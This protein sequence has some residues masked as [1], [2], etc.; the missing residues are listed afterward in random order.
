MKLYYQ[1][2]RNLGCEELQ[3]YKLIIFGP[4]GVGKSSLFKVLLGKNPDTVRNSTGAFNRK[5]VQAKVAITTPTSESKSSWHLVNIKDEISR[6]RSII[7]R[8]I[9]KRKSAEVG[10]PADFIS[11]NE[12]QMKIEEEL[13]KPSVAESA[14]IKYASILMVCYDSGGQPEFFDIMPALTTIPTG[15]IMV[16]NLTKDLY[17]KIDSE[18]YEEGESSQSQYQAHYTTAELM[19]TAIANIQSYSAEKISSVTSSSSSSGSNAGRLL[20]V[21]THL[22]LCGK[23]SREKQRIIDKMETVM[24]ND[25]LAGKLMQM[26]HCDF[27]GRIIHCISNKD[28]VG[29]DKAAQKIRTAIEDMSKQHEKS[30]SEV[31]INWLL[32][33]LEIQLEMQLTGKEYIGWNKC[34]EIAKDCYIKENEVGSV[35]MYFHELGVLLHYKEVD[36]LKDIIFCN[37]QWLFDQLT[38]L[39]KIKYKATPMIQKNINK[40]TLDKQQLCKLYSKKLDLKGELK[41][42]N[43][44][45]LFVHLKIMSKLPNKPDQYFM[46]ALLNPAPTNISLQEQIGKKVH[47]TMLV[48]FKDRYFPR[49]MFCCLVTQLSQNGWEI[50]CM[51]AYKN[52]IVFQNLPNQYIVLYDEINYMEVEIHCNEETNFQTNHYEVCIT[53]NDCL[54][55]VCEM[56]QMNCNFELGFVCKNCKIFAGVESLN[57]YSLSTKYCCRECGS[58]FDLNHGQLVWFLPPNIF[59]LQV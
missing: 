23:T 3:L 9:K 54:T 7:E 8:V 38:E 44:L 33:Q 45:E 30:Y 28:S 48:K 59:K 51:H 50:Q 58:S 46:P 31:P 11:H 2:K 13:F 40:G 19:K 21:G 37:P 20:V 43:L 17:S 27:D 39:I 12:S 15:N 41:F 4:P 29:R 1:A 14:E 49:G 56:F 10:L 5:L 16:F 52:L 18:Y 42:E 25:I 6:L 55:K 34:V 47:D 57:Q 26:V 24:C 32:F 53:L 22:D 35:L 36:G